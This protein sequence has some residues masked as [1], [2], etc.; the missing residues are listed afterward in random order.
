MT[1]CFGPRHTKPFFPTMD[2]QCVAFLASSIHRFAAG[3]V[4]LS[5]ARPVKYF[6]CRPMWLVYAGRSVLFAFCSRLTA[7]PTRQPCS[8]KAA[9]WMPTATL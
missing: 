1:L 4:C 8:P 7:V 3:N 9:A 5:H 6:R 2:Q